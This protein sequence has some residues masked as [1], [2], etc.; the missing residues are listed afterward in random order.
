MDGVFLVQMVV[1]IV[2]NSLCGYQKL[3]EI[4]LLTVKVMPQFVRHVPI[5]I[6]LCESSNLYGR[7]AVFLHIM[8]KS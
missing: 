1:E 6:R 3:L 5:Q 8:V 7:W 4:Y 2:V